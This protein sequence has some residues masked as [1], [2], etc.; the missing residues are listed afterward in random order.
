M[1]LPFQPSPVSLPSSEQPCP[2]QSTQPVPSRE[3]NQLISP[4]ENLS[5]EGA[6]DT[7]RTR[8]GLA[9]EAGGGGVGIKKQLKILK[10]RD[11]EVWTGQAPGQM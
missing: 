9:K 2:P 1:G 3:K 7:G 6:H 8:L 5:E 11:T 4:R 10:D